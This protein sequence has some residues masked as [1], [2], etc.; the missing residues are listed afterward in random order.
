MSVAL[1]ILA[2]SAPSIAFLN[3]NLG[4]SEFV[5][6][7]EKSNSDD[8]LLT[9]SGNEKMM[10]FD[11]KPIKKGGWPSKPFQITHRI[12]LV[13][14]VSEAAQRAGLTDLSYATDYALFPHTAH[15]NKLNMYDLCFLLTVRVFSS[16]PKPEV[17]PIQIEF[18][19]GWSGKLIGSRPVFKGRCVETP[20]PVIQK[21]TR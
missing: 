5:C 1:F 6:R 19:E 21:S 2:Q 7:S 16:K 12:N 8:F 20:L 17:E 3:F 10:L 14:R 11:V 18:F 9:F 4:R 13:Q 15:S